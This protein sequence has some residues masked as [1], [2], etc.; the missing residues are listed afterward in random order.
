MV[1]MTKEQYNS[2]NKKKGKYKNKKNEVDGYSFDSIAESN[3]FLELKILQAG[4]V[5]KS[6]SLQPRF[7]LQINNSLVCTYVGDF[8]YIKTEN[9]ETVVEDVK[10]VR[11]RTFIIKKK[12]M[13]AI[14]GIEV[15]EI[16]VLKRK[17]RDD[18]AKIEKNNIRRANT[19][20]RRNKSGRN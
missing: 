7:K 8:S 15:T 14:Y 20:S 11:T 12:L 5:I 16:N 6:L 9:N 10:A 1:R 3:R 17:K 13:H 19:A 2:I 4:G 18:N